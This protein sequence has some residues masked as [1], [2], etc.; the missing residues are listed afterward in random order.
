MAKLKIK[1]E[2]ANT[3]IGFN[4]SA[5]PLG[6]RDDLEVLAKI[7]LDSQDSTLLNL[8][9]ESPEPDTVAQITE[10]KILNDTNPQPSPQPAK[11]HRT[12]AKPRSKQ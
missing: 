1:S 12:A 2:F 5:L 3:V 11:K 9:E 6:K 4:N 10:E 7:A 8:F